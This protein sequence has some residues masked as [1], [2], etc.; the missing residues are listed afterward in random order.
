MNHDAYY[1]TSTTFKLNIRSSKVY[2]IIS[3]ID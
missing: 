2:F 3:S 1:I